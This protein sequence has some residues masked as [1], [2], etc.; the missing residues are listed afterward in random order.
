MNAAA[1]SKIDL[2]WLKQ[3]IEILSETIEKEKKRM[4]RRE[5]VNGKALI[6]SEVIFE[7]D[8]S[9]HLQFVYPKQAVVPWICE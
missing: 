4:G 9:I 7:R 6:V 1:V 3:N 2:K 8:Y 5:G